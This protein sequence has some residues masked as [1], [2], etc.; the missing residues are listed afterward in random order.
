MHNLL[1]WVRLPAPQHRKSDSICESDFVSGWE[2]QFTPK[3]LSSNLF[4]DSQPRNQGIK[5]K[6]DP[7]LGSFLYSALAGL[8]R[9]ISHD[10]PAN[11]LFHPRPAGVDEVHIIAGNTIRPT[12]L[13]SRSAGHNSPEAL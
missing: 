1:G 12:G 6:K 9:F 11:L 10:S 13:V 2:E 7:Y 3:N 8:V 5:Y 4:G